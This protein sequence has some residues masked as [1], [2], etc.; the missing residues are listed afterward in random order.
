MAVA[1]VLN[2]MP[3]LQPSVAEGLE[4]LKLL[5]AD[6]QNGGCTIADWDAGG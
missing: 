5:L 2:G 6:R 3:D 1:L 4:C